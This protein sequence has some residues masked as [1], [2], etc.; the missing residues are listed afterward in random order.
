MIANHW[1]QPY[2]LLMGVNNMDVM[3][4]ALCDSGL[5]YAPFI[6]AIVRAIGRSMTEGDDEG[7]AGEI[8]FKYLRADL[9]RIMPIMILAFIP[10]SGGV[11]SADYSAQTALK[12]C[13]SVSLISSDT[14][15][16]S[17][18]GS[19]GNGRNKVPM[20]W[21]GVHD[22][23]AV[24]TN[25]AVA[26]MPCPADL[27][28][29]QTNLNSAA[30]TDLADQQ[31][32][33]AWGDACFSTAANSLTKTSPYVQDW[34]AG[35]QDFLQQYAKD[36]SSVTLPAETAAAVGLSGT[37]SGA[38]VR[39]NC[40][41]AYQH[42]MSKSLARISSIP[43]AS[44]VAKQVGAANNR[45]EQEVMNITAAS[46]FANVK[47]PYQKAV[48]VNGT[49]ILVSGT[50]G[51]D[52]ANDQES[53]AGFV[54]SIKQTLSNIM[55]APDAITYMQ[56]IP[57]QSAIAQMLLLSVLPLLLVCTGFD[58]KSFLTLS[59]LYFGIE[60]TPAI[61]AFASWC[62]G[63]L[64]VLTGDITAGNDGGAFSNGGGDFSYEFAKGVG[65]QLYSLLPATWFSLLTIVGVTS[66]SPLGDFG[67]SSGNIVKLGAIAL[68]V[69]KAMKTM[70]ASLVK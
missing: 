67:G 36:S 42:L 49:T 21:A 66:L 43:G 14:V 28:A 55:N 70:G 33:K 40:L 57:I 9:L 69:A 47:N 52:S 39:I 50:A 64:A 3:I 23:S 65:L 13:S 63:M 19:F 1:I 62:D 56:G 11:T 51:Q 38:S 6:F 4:E 2:T 59:V 68:K 32:A 31:L 48:S 7:N 45:S 29:V 22:L 20:W 18:T 10:M 41:T 34:W 17:M 8:A 61:A 24:I 35:H 53:F 5:V 16:S 54:A 27:N 58:A 44:D 12:T 15:S 46:L 25:T 60:F 26:S 30:F 37:G